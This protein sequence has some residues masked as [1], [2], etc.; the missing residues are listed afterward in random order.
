MKK[1]KVAT[2]ALFSAIIIFIMKILAFFLSNSIAL[3]SDALESIVNIA[4]SGLMFFSIIISEKPPDSSHKYGHQ[5]SEDISS[6]TEGILIILAASL[7]ISTAI[8]RITY[9]IELLKFDTA[10]IVSIFATLLN[11]GVFILLKKSATKSDSIALEGD[12]NHLLSDVISTLIVW[13]GLLIFKLTGWIIIDPLLALLGSVLI[14]RMGIRLIIKSSNRLMD[15]SCIE[16]EKRIMEVLE[17]HRFNFIDFHNLKTRRH[18]N[19]IFAE[20]HLSVD[21]SLSIKEGHDLTDHL[22]KDLTKEISNCHVI[23]HIEPPED[24]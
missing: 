4:A 16:E 11:I 20:I 13:I 21:A 1:K 18:G 12:A 22:E 17:R 6:L 5:K 24:T 3:L 23:I 19:K 10:I 9:P 15:Q 7:I 2:L 8:G 14:L